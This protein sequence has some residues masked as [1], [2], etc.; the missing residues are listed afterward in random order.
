MSADNG[1]TVAKVEDA[2]G[3]GIFY[4]QG[5]HWGNT[6]ESRAAGIY[7]D[8]VAAVLAA[9]RLDQGMAA[10]EYGVHLSDE[11]REA[12]EPYLERADRLK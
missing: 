7:S 10:T 5:V 2:P 3:Y 1:Y 4:W 9:H 11:V 6:L 8:P 12:C